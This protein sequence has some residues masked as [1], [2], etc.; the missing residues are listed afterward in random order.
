MLA[1]ITLPKWQSASGREL[2]WVLESLIATAKCY[3]WKM[4]GE[5]VSYILLLLITLDMKLCQ[6]AFRLRRNEQL[7]NSMTQH[8]SGPYQRSISGAFGL[9]SLLWKNNERQHILLPDSFDGRAERCV[10]EMGDTFSHATQR[11]VLKSAEMT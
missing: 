3:K 1:P 8:A 2:P 4:N 7:P 9:S 11:K 6:H 5:R 10:S